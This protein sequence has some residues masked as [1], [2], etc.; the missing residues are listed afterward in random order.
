MKNKKTMHELC[1]EFPNKSY[2]E[3][4]KYRNADRQEEAQQIFTQQ[5]NEEL[6][7]SQQKQEELEPIEGVD[8]EEIYKKEHELR[9]KTEKELADLKK[10]IDPAHKIQKARE[11]GL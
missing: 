9:Q 5:E 1:K 7:E 11:S 8:W 3:L 6:T 2:R 4:E 10:K